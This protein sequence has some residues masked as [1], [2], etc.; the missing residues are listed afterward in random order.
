MKNNIVFLKNGYLRIANIIDDI[1]NIHRNY[2][3]ST[4]QVASQL[5]C[6][7][8]INPFIRPE[9]GITIY[10]HDNTQGPICSLCC[11]AGLAY[12]NYI[13]NGGQTY[14]KQI[15]VLINVINNI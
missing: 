3:N 6:L 5:N 13:Y 7:E 15:R 12:R 2:K 11:P 10:A 4:I 1:R 8:M 14:N 9:N